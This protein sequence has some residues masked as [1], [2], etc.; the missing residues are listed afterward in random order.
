MRVRDY[1]VVRREN[2]IVLVFWKAILSML[3]APEA[4]GQAILTL[5][6]KPCLGF[7]V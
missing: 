3:I 4:N 2:V 6:P 5:N 1:H 7:R